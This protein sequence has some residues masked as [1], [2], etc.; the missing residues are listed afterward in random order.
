LGT[1]YFEYKKNIEYLK[2]SSYE[3]KKEQISSEI[4]RTIAL[5]NY[6]YSLKMKRIK[7]QVKLRVYEAHLISQ[8]IYEKYR[9]SKT[10]DE[11]VSLIKESLRNTRF[12]D[13]LGYFFIYDLKGKSILH[14]L[15]PDIENTYKFK[16]F[17]DLNGKIVIPGWIENLKTKPEDHDTWTFYRVDDKE[18]QAIKVGFYKLF[19][20]Y[21][22]IIATADY[23][24]RVKEELQ[25][26]TIER[27][28]Q[29]NDDSEL[30]I[31]IMNTD[32]ITL[33]NR[34]FPSFENKHYDDLKNEKAKVILK[35][36]INEGNESGKYL[37][38][39][40]KKTN[41]DTYQKK[42]S[43]IKSYTKWDWIIGSGVFFDDIE[44]IIDLK[45]KELNKEIMIDIVFILFFILS[46]LLIVF[47]LTKQ[48]NK[49][50]NNSLKLF[51]NFFKEVDDNNKKIDLDLI[52][53]HE[54]YKIAKY[55]NKMI[56]TKNKNE[57]EIDSKNK[58]VLINISLLDEYKKAV[59]AAALVSKADID[60]KITYINDQFCKIS[61]YSEAELINKNHNVVRHPDVAPNVF[62]NLW[63]TILD[64]KI[65][66]GVFKN[67]AKDGSTYYVKST[68]IPILDIKG[69][70]KEFIAI[71]YDV[72]DLIEQSRK[73]KFQTTDL[74]TNLPNRQK[75]LEDINAKDHLKLL[76]I[77]IE[78]FKEINEYYGYEV[79]DKALIETS[80]ILSLLITNNNLKLFKLQGD[81]FAILGNKEI[82]EKEFKETSI[83]FIK[84]LE[85]TQLVIDGN[86]LDINFIAGASFIR[87]YFINAEMAR[88]YAKQENKSLI[89]FDENTDIKDNLINNIYWT[90]K[91]KKS[92]NENKIVVVAQPIISNKNISKVTKYECLV[93]I[94]DDDGSLISPMHFLNI[95]K[96]SNLYT[97]ITQ[98]VIEKSFTHFSKNE[99]SFSIN[100]TI[101]DILDKNTVD[102]IH[103]KLTE[104]EGI[105]NRLIFEIVEDEGI[106]NYNEVITFIEEMKYLGCSIA[107]DDFG[108]GYSN[109][110]YLMKLNVD[111][112]KIDGS[113]IKYL[114]HDENAKVVTELVVKFAEK[115]NIK[116]IGEF[117]HS[118]EIHEIV[119][120]MGIDY[121]QGFYLG[122][123]KRIS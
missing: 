44:K 55:A 109:F 77:N 95:A 30:N 99:D 110:D 68:I 118:K 64:K 28:R 49:K 96:K 13:G 37:S 105:S 14:P 31:F 61:G 15:R 11:I 79:G 21:D 18:K 112:V 104:Y 97:K 32:G 52:E 20:P 53:Y 47:L 7:N 106:E 17:K 19:E 86:T 58:E 38:Y 123:P 98:I 35:R 100:L 113:M 92:I 75:L 10:K 33:L 78:R 115:L 102:F 85:Y 107:I 69:E 24:Y 108:T 119:T 81:V 56:D 76:I 42:L 121:S 40:W 41:S 74:L 34:N 4:N 84:K 62:K 23:L 51:L 29:I 71:R 117:V 43:Y 39:M 59:D 80:K 54:F 91:L 25:K 60:G 3:Q 5:L 48:I 70:I 1:T 63:N 57:K 22:F 6:N 50:I 8:K 111:Y 45:D 16:N 116:T 89:F 101:E 122:K 83:K 27:I 114:D 36:I 65:W 46:I 120:K 88:N 9:D 94:E 93:R 72:T 67:L 87:N 26:E 2:I 12:F 103:E 90:K 66:K 82:S 73:I